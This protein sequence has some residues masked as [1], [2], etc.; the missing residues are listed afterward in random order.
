MLYFF[1]TKLSENTQKINIKIK[2]TDENVVKLNV[3]IKLN[4]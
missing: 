1:I 4:V 3:F 2:N